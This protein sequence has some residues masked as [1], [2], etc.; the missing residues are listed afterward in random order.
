MKSHTFTKDVLAW[1]MGDGA[2]P[3]ITIGKQV[4][5]FDLPPDDL[6]SLAVLLLLAA[7]QQEER[8]GEIAEILIERVMQ[9]QGGRRGV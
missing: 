2:V 5:R 6:R 7:E 4:A 8:A 1:R 9:K 3:E